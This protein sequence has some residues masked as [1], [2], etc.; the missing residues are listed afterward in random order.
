MNVCHFVFFNEA[1]YLCSAGAGVEHNFCSSQ[2]KTLHARAGQRQ[3]VS[4]R[5]HREQNRTLLNFRMFCCQFGITNIV[6]VSS[7]DKFRNSG[8]PSRQ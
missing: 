8:G 2:H 7:G 1:E 6:V 5:Q 3:V 4:N